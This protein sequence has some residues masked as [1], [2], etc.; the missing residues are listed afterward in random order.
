MRAKEFINSD[1]KNEGA[2]GGGALGAVAGGLIGGG[3][4]AA[5]GAWIGAAIGLHLENIK[6]LE[7]AIQNLQ[8]TT[9]SLNV[10]KELAIYKT[11]HNEIIEKNKE[12]NEIIFK[13]PDPTIRQKYLDKID[14]LTDW[15]SETD[16]GD[17]DDSNNATGDE[18]DW[19]ESHDLR[20][21]NALSKILLEIKQIPG[22]K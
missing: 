3:V 17:Y 9:T 16:P 1:I 5:I 4:G 15:W 21:L 22:I 7:Q 8:T 14:K 10:E 20:Y 6:R 13:I 19:Y 18:L 11:K 2:I 12:I